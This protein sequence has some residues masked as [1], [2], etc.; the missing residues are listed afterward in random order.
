MSD[1][2]TRVHELLAEGKSGAEVAKELGL[3]AAKVSRLK[4]QM[5][6]QVQD[7]TPSTGDAARDEYRRKLRELLPVS[8][9]AKRLADLARS[10]QPAVA[11]RAIELADEIS[12]LGADQQQMPALV[13]MFALPEGTKSPFSK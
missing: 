7:T 1:T 13:P 6:S 4:K 8:E 10:K 9:R 2:A 11:L 5:E 3:S 12:G